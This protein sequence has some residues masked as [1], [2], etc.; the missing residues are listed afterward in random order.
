VDY[1]E[2]DQDPTGQAYEE[3]EKVLVYYELD[4]G[5]RLRSGFSVAPLRRGIGTRNAPWLEWR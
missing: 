3:I 5:L 4:L 1:S 2:A